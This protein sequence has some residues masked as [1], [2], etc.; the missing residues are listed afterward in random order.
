MS[1]DAVAILVTSVMASP[2][3]LYL[4][5]IVMPETQ[6]PAATPPP[7]SS[8]EDKPANVIDKNAFC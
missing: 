4:T 8:D 7:P 2:C 1:T 6:T 5:K 3:T